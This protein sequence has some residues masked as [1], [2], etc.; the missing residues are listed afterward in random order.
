MAFVGLTAVESLP[1]AA[2]FWPRAFL[3]LFG[4]FL[5]LFGVF[6]VRFGG[7]LALFGVFLLLFGEFFCRPPVRGADC[8]FKCWSCR[9]RRSCSRVSFL[10]R[11]ATLEAMRSPRAGEER[12]AMETMVAVS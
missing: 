11:S 7:F 10:V 8:T 12:F 4:V 6:W 9:L 2:A 3:L 5:L 1:A